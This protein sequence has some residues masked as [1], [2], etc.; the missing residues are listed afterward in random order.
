MSS[1]HGIEVSRE[2]V[3][4]MR[5][6]IRSFKLSQ[7]K[8]L[9]RTLLLRVSGKKADLITRIDEFIEN[10]ERY[11]DKVKL[12]VIG[13]IIKKIVMHE[14]VPGYPS[15]YNAIRY[16]GYRA[17]TLNQHQP[18]TRNDST[19]PA[20][21][22]WVNEYAPKHSDKGTQPYT[23]HVVYFKDSPFYTLKKM[24]DGSPQVVWPSTAR[25]V[26]KLSF[27]L[28]EEDNV[29]F[30]SKPGKMKVFLVCAEVD[31]NAASTPSAAI[32][33]PTPLEIHANGVQLRENVKG[34][35]GKPGTARPANITK[36]INRTPATN[37]VEMVYAANAKYFLMYCYIAETRLSDEIALE[38]MKNRHIH[39][40]STID[41][42]KKEYTNGDDDLV[43]A[44]SSLS[45]KCP[46]TYS[47]MKLPSKSIYC[48]HIQCFDCLS[49]LQLQEQIPTWTCPIC[50]R[51][52]ELDEIAV[53]DYYLDIL[54]KVDDNVDS[55][56]LNPDGSWSPNVESQEPTSSPSPHTGQKTNPVDDV[57]EIVSIDSESE[58]ETPSRPLVQ[59]SSQPVEL[60]HS[61]IDSHNRSTE[62]QTPSEQQQPHPTTI[63]IQPGPSFAPAPA[64]S[65]IPSQDEPPR[66]PN[67]IEAGML[68]QSELSSASIQPRPIP[69]EPELSVITHIN[70]P[71][72]TFSNSV[73]PHS[74]SQDRLNAA[75]NDHSQ[76]IPSSQSVEPRSSLPGVSTTQSSPA[77][78]QLPLHQEVILPPLRANSA[79]GSLPGLSSF[80]FEPTVDSSGA[81]MELPAAMPNPVASPFDRINQALRTQ[82]QQA[83]A[84]RD[85]QERYESLR[86]N[87]QNNLRRSHQ[88]EPSQPTNPPQPA[89]PPVSEQPAGM[90]YSRSAFDLLSA[91]RQDH[92]A[93]ML[94]KTRTNANGL[95]PQ[96]TSLSPLNGQIE[97]F[98]LQTPQHNQ[99]PVQ[100]TWNKRLHSEERSPS[101]TK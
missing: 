15:L 47:R 87:F 66:I 36:F 23:S 65:S 17:D 37:V 26:T 101:P 80:S 81:R 22:G 86:Y 70:Q 92:M 3:E 42:I 96:G 98:S 89:S 51:K 73:T 72:T 30:R 1:L 63:P 8:D 48:Q 40:V 93:P 28:S 83:E 99:V 41:E 21:N 46:L 6:R 55:V 35:K 2:D 64:L 10:G 68:S 20:S 91:N 79:A 88:S 56:T 31:L 53:S 34:I 76:I 50:S 39:L 14:D 94:K 77:S 11:D 71:D 60:I 61:P 13:V 95:S 67:Q 32:E 16:G 9:A 90:T 38:V 58:D 74:A 78:A 97:D 5:K 59:P 33:Y 12:L 4:D 44:T 69:S 24:I 85:Q 7:L 49:F 82:Q 100:R 52:M 19:R 84:R 29:L 57:V 62:P 43:V 27:R 75:A 54:L 45:L 25:K 18:D